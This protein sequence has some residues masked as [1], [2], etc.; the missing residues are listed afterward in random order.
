MILTVITLAFGISELDAQQT[1]KFKSTAVD[2]IQDSPSNSKIFEEGIDGT[3]YNTNTNPFT[4]NTPSEK[5]VDRFVFGRDN[6][7]GMID[8]P[9][10]RTAPK[11][12]GCYIQGN[13]SWR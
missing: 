9:Y 13:K 3:F 11:S 7:G 5:F 10:H 12:G 4:G 1:L 8:K 6:Y 2:A